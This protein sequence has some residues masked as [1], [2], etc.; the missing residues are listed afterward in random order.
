MLHVR[1]SDGLLRPVFGILTPDDPR[2]RRILLR[3]GVS[4]SEKL[5]VLLMY[6]GDNDIVK[7]VYII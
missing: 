4:G 2:T 5:W 7:A 3:S 6:L 1:Q